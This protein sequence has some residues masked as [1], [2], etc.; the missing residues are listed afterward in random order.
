MNMDINFVFTFMSVCTDIEKK[1]VENHIRMLKKF[2]DLLDNIGNENS[3]NSNNDHNNINDHNDDDNDNKTNN[4]NNN[5]NNNDHDNNDNDNDNDNEDLLNCNNISLLNNIFNQRIQLL[6]G[7]QNSYEN[8]SHNST[9]N[10]Q[11]TIKTCDE[12]Q[13]TNQ[14]ETHLQQLIFDQVHQQSFQQGFEQNIS[15]ITLTT[16]SSPHPN[17]S[18]DVDIAINTSYTP[19]VPDDV[20]NGNNN[21]DYNVTSQNQTQQQAQQAQQ[22]LGNLVR[23]RSTIM[24]SISSSDLEHVQGEQYGSDGDGSNKNHDT[25]MSKNN[26]I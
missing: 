3:V 23:A 26:S 21:C 11:V 2:D 24:P 13:Q 14:N 4:N 25:S 12:K 9:E 18:R 10:N 6:G 1:K 20:I 17:R 5:N 16:A 22:A 8:F 7:L 15:D 19:N